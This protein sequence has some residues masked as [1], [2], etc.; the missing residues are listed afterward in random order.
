MPVACYN[1]SPSSLLPDKEESNYLA[2]KK[3]KKECKPQR[4]QG[5]KNAAGLLPFIVKLYL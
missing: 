3:P 1:M 5:Y 2:V 4:L